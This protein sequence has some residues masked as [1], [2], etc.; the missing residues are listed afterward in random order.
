ML[1]VS[2]RQASIGVR[3]IVVFG[4]RQPLHLHFKS[5]NIILME[6]NIV[7]RGVSAVWL[8]SVALP[9]VIER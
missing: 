2:M 9:G 8:H 4:D 3:S 1:R 6:K 7:P 5:E